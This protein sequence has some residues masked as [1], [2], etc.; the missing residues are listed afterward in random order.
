MLYSYPLILF[1]LQNECGRVRLVPSDFTIIA[2]AS[3]AGQ[4]PHDASTCNRGDLSYLKKMA[5]WAFQTYV[6]RMADLYGMRCV[7]ALMTRFG[8][9][10]W[11]RRRVRDKESAEDENAMQ[12]LPVSG[13]QTLVSSIAKRA[14]RAGVHA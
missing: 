8:R 10:D 6:R 1:D 5:I 14:L 12:R 4:A 7:N 3:A 11:F 2:G 13:V 9:C